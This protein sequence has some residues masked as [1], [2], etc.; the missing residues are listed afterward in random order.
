M[1]R[2]ILM[3]NKVGGR[4]LSGLVPGSLLAP[5]AKQA[6]ARE[7]HSCMTFSSFFPQTTNADCLAP[8]SLIGVSIMRMYSTPT[9][10]ITPGPRR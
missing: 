1:S 7:R 2:A 4:A 8:P 6:P 3:A 5:G 9:A 10:T